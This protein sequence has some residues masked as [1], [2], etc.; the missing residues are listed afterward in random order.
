MSDKPEM[1]PSVLMVDGNG[2]LHPNRAGVASHIG[3]A[4]GNKLEKQYLMGSVID[5]YFSQMPNGL[6]RMI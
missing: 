6:N 5:T 3:K 2:I 4:A 1:T